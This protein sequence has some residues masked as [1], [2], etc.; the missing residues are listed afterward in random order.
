MICGRCRFLNS[1]SHFLA[2]SL[3]I[4]CPSHTASKLLHQPVHFY[5]LEVFTCQFSCLSSMVYH[6]T[7]SK[8]GNAV[9]GRGMKRER[10]SVLYF[11][12]CNKMENLT[13]DL[14]LLFYLVKGVHVTL[15]LSQSLFWACQLWFFRYAPSSRQTSQEEGKEWLR[16]HSTGGLQDTGSQSP[17]VSPSA[18]SS[19]ATGKYHFSNL[20]KS[21]FPSLF[22]PL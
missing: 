8:E 11:F 16:S 10:V 4:P 13:L 14:L 20:G 7:S 9:L 17:L 12:C 5:S 21:H 1:Y 18:M 15:F 3:P 22:L 19:S 6:H 2:S